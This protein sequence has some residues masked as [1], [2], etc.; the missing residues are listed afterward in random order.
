MSGPAVDKGGV[1]EGMHA[2][3]TVKAVSEVMRLLR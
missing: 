2:S 1:G 3:A